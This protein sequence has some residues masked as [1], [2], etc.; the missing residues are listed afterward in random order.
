MKNEEED[1]IPRTC[2]MCLNH[3]CSTNES[4]SQLLELW[5]NKKTEMLEYF[6]KWCKNYIPSST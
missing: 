1:N 6:E 5:Q 4:F 3:R 2:Y